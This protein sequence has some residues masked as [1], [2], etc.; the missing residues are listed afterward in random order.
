MKS[1]QG[2]GVGG[3][4]GEQGGWID[5]WRLDVWREVCS[6]LASIH[7]RAHQRRSDIYGAADCRGLPSAA[8]TEK[9][10]IVNSTEKTV[11]ASDYR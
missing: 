8:G 2:G 10:D 11:T 3:G 1:K 7:R 9:R 5:R 6:I 4:D